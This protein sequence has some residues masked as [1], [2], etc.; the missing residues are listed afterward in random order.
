MI[1]SR[2]FR[3]YL[4]LIGWENRPPASP[5]LPIKF[6]KKKFQRLK[7]CN[8]FFSGAFSTGP[9]I[10]ASVRLATASTTTIAAATMSTSAWSTTATVPT[11]ASTLSARTSV[12]APTGQKNDFQERERSLFTFFNKVSI[13]EH[14][15]F[16]GFRT[17]TGFVPKRFSYKNGFRTKMVFVPKMVRTKNSTKSVIRTKNGSVL[18]PDYVQKTDFVQKTVFVQKTIC[19]WYENR[20]TRTL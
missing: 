4:S 14:Y 18:N 7:S 11:A 8:A 15:E 2:K 10:T 20:W 1:G 19:L 6:E 9:D 17:K 16:N 3:R 12:S 5:K 13:F